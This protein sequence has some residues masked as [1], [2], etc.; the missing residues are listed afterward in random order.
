MSI[1]NKQCIW[2]TSQHP[3]VSN[4][5]ITPPNIDGD[6]LWVRL[7]TYWYYNEWNFKL[8]KTIAKTKRE[9]MV[10]IERR[11]KVGWLQRSKNSNQSLGIKVRKPSL[12]C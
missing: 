2:A 5:I 7:C 11:T 6:I 4:E 8:K 12:A 3:T 1:D 9:N 10:K